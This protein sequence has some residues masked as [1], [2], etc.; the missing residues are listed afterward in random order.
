MA[1]KLLKGSKYLFYLALLLVLILHATTLLFTYPFTYD[2]FTH[3]FFA[4][5]YSNNW[6]DNWNYKWYAGFNAISYPPL[7][8]QIIG[9]FSKLIGLQWAFYVWSLLVL[10]FLVRGIYH[11]ASLWVNEKAAALSAVLF[12]F[13]GSLVEALHFFGQVPFLTG[14]ACLL[15]ACPFLYKWILRKQRIYLILTL[16]L[17]TVNAAAHHVTVI[18]GMAFFIFPTIGLALYDRT[19]LKIEEKGKIQLKHIWNELVQNFWSL[20]GFGI[21]VLV[22]ML[23]VIL[24]YWI[25][26]GSDPIDQVSIPHG[27]RESFIEKPMLGIVFFLIPWGL[28]LFSIPYI[29]LSSFRK[30][31]V[32]LGLSLILLFILGLGGTI[33]LPRL[34]LG[35][36]AFDI[37]TM[38]RFT[39]WATIL[40]LP[41]FAEFIIKVFS[42]TSYVGKMFRIFR[43]AI[44]IFFTIGTILFSLFIINLNQLNSFQPA[45][46]DPDPIVKFMDADQHKSWRYCTLGFGDQMA[47]LATKTDALSIDGNYHSARRLPEMTSRAIERIENAK[48]KGEEGL[49]SLKEFLTIPEKFNLK[50]IFSNDKFYDPILFFTGWNKVVQLENKVVVWERPDINPLKKILPRQNIPLYQ[51]YLWGILPLSS[52]AIFLLIFLY[53]LIFYKNTFINDKAIQYAKSFV[54]LKNV[55]A[56]WLTQFSWITIIFLSFFGYAWTVNVELNDRSDASKVLDNYYDFLSIDKKEKAYNLLDAASKPSYDQFLLDLNVS[57]GIRSSYAIY[58]SLL[59][60]NKIYFTKNKVKATY[61]LYLTTSVGTYIQTEEHDLTKINNSWSIVYK[62]P[63]KKIPP[64][65]FYSKADLNF[66]GQGRR[67]IDTNHTRKE[68]IL[69]RPEAYILN[70]SLVKKDKNYFILGE[71]QNIDHIPS[72]LVV[73]GILKNKKDEIIAKYNCAELLK[74]R[75]LPQ[76]KTVF[77]IDFERISKE[78]LIAWNTD[79]VDAKYKKYFSEEPHSFEVFLRTTMCDKIP[80]KNVGYDDLMFEANKL[81]ANLVN[82][83]T[84]DITIPQLLLAEYNNEDKIV[85]VSS[86]FLKSNIKAQKELD[87]SMDL[88]NNEIKILQNANPDNLYVNGI[89]KNE[90]EKFDE[91]NNHILEDQSSVLNYNGKKYKLFINSFVFE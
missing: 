44:L 72:Y 78:D 35:D 39:F 21:A 12:V 29:F 57:D 32:F 45:K 13:T 46:I 28:M 80:Y 6:F 2:A 52:L 20:I 49:K 34:I 1:I 4:D 17:L 84:K 22:L 88:D 25:M 87:F 58:D 67:K 33:S 26:A 74:H 69:D 24:P 81:K 23:I 50:Y 36:T 18:F 82:T 60:K 71:I 30:R 61:D 62:S 38:D 65:L 3:I 37:L 66:R 47:W 55:K 19:I 48:F 43:K 56:F 11:F 90:H 16:S 63:E 76:E 8:H 75:I 64:D 70:A 15:N 86:M 54:W 5:H 77:R 79:L 91:I 85:W 73:E 27:S 83:G 68:D 7:V 40:S 59:L 51:N 31:N 10:C 9:L 42:N 14:M 89:S 41:L 53:Y